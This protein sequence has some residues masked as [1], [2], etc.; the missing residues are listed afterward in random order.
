MKTKILKKIWEPLVCVI[1]PFVIPLLM[2]SDYTQAHI[3]KPMYYIIYISLVCLDAFG[4]IWIQI[5]KK[6]IEDGLWTNKA[7]RHL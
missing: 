6:Q 3:E 5:K 1:C 4:I 7:S 2:G